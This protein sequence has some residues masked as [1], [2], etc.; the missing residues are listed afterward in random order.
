PCTGSVTPTPEVCGD[1]LDNDCDGVTDDGCV[2]SPGSAAPCYDGPGG[3]EGVGTCSAGVQFCN[4]TG[5]AYGACTGS[6]TPV[7]EIC[8]DNLDNDCDGTVDEGC[9][10]TAGSTAACY[11]GPPSTEDI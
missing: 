11:S 7:A 9:V 1:N 8:G 10:C 5:T 3:T 6:V 2:C 4:A